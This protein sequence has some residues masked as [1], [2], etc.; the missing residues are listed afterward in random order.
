[1]HKDWYLKV[2]VLVF[3]ISVIQV[4]SAEYAQEMCNRSSPLSLAPEVYHSNMAHMCMF[5]RYIL[6]V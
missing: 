2:Y 3:V 5:I 1:M 6:Y 4:E